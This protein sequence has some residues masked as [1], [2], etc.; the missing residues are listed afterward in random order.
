MLE[1][2][3][4]THKKVLNLA[5]RL[6]G[7]SEVEQLEME[8]AVLSIGLVSTNPTSSEKEEEIRRAQEKLKSEIKLARM[9]QGFWGRLQDKIRNEHYLW[10]S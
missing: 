1:K 10:C 6:V 8:E 9:R 3:S 2:G 5:R 7:C 4:P